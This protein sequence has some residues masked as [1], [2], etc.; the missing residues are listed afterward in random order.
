MHSR[1]MD[2]RPV[3]TTQQMEP[4]ETGA[5]PRSHAVEAV[6]QE[7]LESGQKSGNYRDGL[8]RVLTQWHDR[9]GAEHVGEIDKRDMARY[10]QYLTRRVDANQNRDADGGI[11]AGTAWTYY[12]YVSAFLSHCVKWDYLDENPAQK[13]AA[14]DEMPPR[15]KNKSGEQQFWSTE[16]R[17]RLLSY[18]DRRAD[19]ALD[20]KGLD[21]IEELRDR[22]LAYV[23]AY[24]GVRGGEVLSDPRDERRDGVRWSDL[25]LE[26]GYMTILGKNQTEEQ[27][28]LPSQ[29][30]GPLERLQKA[31][32]P[33]GDSWPVFPSFHAPTLA[34]GLP[35]AVTP[36]EDETYLDYY[37]EHGLSPAALSTNGGRAVLKRLCE[38][39]EID[40]DGGYLTPHGARRGVG[41]LMYRKRGAA[42]AQRTLRHAD[43]RTTSEMYAHIEASE[44]ADEVSDVFKDDEIPDSYK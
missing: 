43:P 40:V 37:R 22:A 29:T 30:H 38:E 8:E 41:E 7:F 3:Q 39:A 9:I 32:R 33:A 35:D 26:D 28:Q 24:S 6:I 27:A 19:Q 10:A 12:D 5:N 17:Q 25:S 14:T 1:L 16:D 36:D 4:S 44:L 13:G 20:E 2:P 42:A 31:L 34:R 11:T 21:A 23:L 18:A 15:P